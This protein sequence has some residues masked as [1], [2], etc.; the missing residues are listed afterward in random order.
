MISEQN[1]LGG[2]A[3]SESVKE[4]G[5]VGEADMYLPRR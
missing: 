1:V 2:E 5:R 4:K 3:L